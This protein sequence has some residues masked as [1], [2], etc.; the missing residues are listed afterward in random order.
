MK[1][2]LNK[3]IVKISNAFQLKNKFNSDMSQYVTL[4]YESLLGRKPI[5]S[6]VDGWIKLNCTYLQILKSF[7]NSEEY[8]D[9]NN[10]QNVRQIISSSN[11]CSTTY[12]VGEDQPIDFDRI[13]FWYKNIAEELSQKNPRHKW[14][15]RHLGVFRH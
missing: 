2:A 8:K 15:F 11:T 1:N 6:E 12:I 14:L 7:I 9:K 10:I 5:Q 4:L 13:L 3:I